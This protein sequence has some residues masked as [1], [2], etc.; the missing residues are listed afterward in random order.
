MGSTTWFTS[1][2]N[3]IRY[4]ETPDGRVVAHFDDGSSA[5]G[6]I[7]VGADGGNSNVR[8][9]FL[10]HAERVETGIVGIAGKVPL[11]DETAPGCRGRSLMGWHPCRLRKGDSC[12]V[13]P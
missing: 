10:P 4:E 9:Q 11:N 5:V 12:S 7:L 2:S 6:D 8:A 13:R 1:T 3:S